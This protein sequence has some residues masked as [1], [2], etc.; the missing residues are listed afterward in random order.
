MLNICLGIILGAIVMEIENGYQIIQTG[1]WFPIIIKII[2]FV[3]VTLLVPG[4]IFIDY[5]VYS[6]GIEYVPID[7]KEE[8]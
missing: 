8:E 5:M 7:K 4:I 3:L 6:L 1:S 2:A